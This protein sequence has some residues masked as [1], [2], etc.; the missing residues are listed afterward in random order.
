[1]VPMSGVLWWLSG[2]AVNLQ[3]EDL[4]S[5]H[6]TA[7]YL[8]RGA[9]LTTLTGLVIVVGAALVSKRPKASRILL[10]CGCLAVVFLSI[11]PVWQLIS[12]K[13]G[14]LWMVVICTGWLVFAIPFMALTIFLY[15]RK[16]PD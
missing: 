4:D 2:L 13:P 8:R 5:V 14:A 12:I 3:A 9:L 16:A 10:M 15:H 7:T 1:M 6:P 11:A